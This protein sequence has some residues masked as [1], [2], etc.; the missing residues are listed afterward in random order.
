MSAA[1]QIVEKIASIGEA[2]AVFVTPSGVIRSLNVTGAHW[3]G[4]QDDPARMARLAGVYDH[5]ATV[6]MI[7]ADIDA[8]IVEGMSEALQGVRN[9]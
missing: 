6:E 3:R 5:R 7:D 8:V 2:R 1:A 9:V 4:A